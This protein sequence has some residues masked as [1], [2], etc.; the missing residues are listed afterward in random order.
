MGGLS[1]VFPMVFVNC[2]ED[3]R[4]A[5]E[6]AASAPSRRM[7]PGQLSSEHQAPLPPAPNPPNAPGLPPAPAPP[8]PALNALT[9]LPNAAALTDPITG[10]TLAGGPQGP[11]PPPSVP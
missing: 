4:K 2:T 3:A 1:A 5:C 8:Q 11:A 7:A 9:A 6:S 10:R